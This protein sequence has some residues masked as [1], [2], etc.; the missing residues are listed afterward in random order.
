MNSFRVT[1]AFILLMIR[2]FVGYVAFSQIQS[3][4]T[5]DINITKDKNGGLYNRMFGMKLDI[6]FWLDTTAAYYIL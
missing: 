4:R 3:S 1:T 6:L 5:M 2:G